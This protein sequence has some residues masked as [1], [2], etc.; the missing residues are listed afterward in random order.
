MHDA[1]P[2]AEKK[3][4]PFLLQ[5]QAQFGLNP[6]CFISLILIFFTSSVHDKVAFTDIKINSGVSLWSHR[7]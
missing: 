4:G 2:I 7:Q 6:A 5:H 3:I 1:M